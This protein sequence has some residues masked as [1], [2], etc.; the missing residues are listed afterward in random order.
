MNNVK[1]IL[2]TLTSGI[3]TV[4]A[5]FGGFNGLL[6]HQNTGEDSMSVYAENAACQSL[7]TVPDGYIG[8]YDIDDLYS[9]RNDLYGNYILMNDIDLSETAPGGEWDSGNGWLPIGNTAEGAFCGF[10]YGNDHKISNMYIYGDIT[11][12]GYY[13]AG[14]FGKVAN[15]EYYSTVIQDL[16][17]EDCNIDIVVKDNRKDI[18]VGGLAGETYYRPVDSCYVTGKINVV[19]ENSDDWFD[20]SVGGITGKV[21]WSAYGTYNCYNTSDITVQ[22]NYNM[23]VGGIAGYSGAPINNVYNT[24]KIICIGSEASVGNIVGDFADGDYF[25]TA[26]YIKSNSEYTA[27]GNMQDSDFEYVK[28]LTASQ[29]KSKGV[30]NLDFEEY[31]DFDALCEAYPYPQLKYVPQIGVTEITLI[32]NPDKTE[33]MK[34]EKIDFTGSK[35]SVKYEDGSQAETVL[36]DEM[37]SENA[38]QKAGKQNVTVTYRNAVTAFE[39]NVID[40]ITGDVTRNGA[41]DLYD[42][43][44]IAKSLIGMR[45]FTETEAKIADYNKDGKVDLYDVI[46]IARYLMTI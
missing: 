16:A 35:L 43:I 6:K 20:L 26:Y 22:C 13:E 34:N 8:V 3:L 15:S 41:V 25:N 46:E 44:E 4:T 10:F 39:I 18:S 11:E 38:T 23:R 12:S 30:Y 29:A 42:A 19:S 40:A 9:V 28:G 7:D 45:T 32:S 1:K 33:Y 2:S 17:L 37:I 5:I 36:T 21:N 24:G 31:W 27:C 14:L